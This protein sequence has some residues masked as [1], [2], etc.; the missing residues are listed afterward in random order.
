MRFIAGLSEEK[1]MVSEAAIVADVINQLQDEQLVQPLAEL[2][3]T[4]YQKFENDR[5]KRIVYGLLAGLFRDKP[6][7]AD[8]EWFVQMGE[9]YKLLISK[10]LSSAQLFDASGENVQRYVFYDDSDAKASFA[11]FIASYKNDPNWRTVAYEQYVE[12]TSVYGHKVTILANKPRDIEKSNF[13]VDEAFKVKNKVPSVIAHRGH[14][15]FFN[16]TIGYV[17]PDVVFV[18]VGACGGAKNVGQLLENSPQAQIAATR[19]VGTMRINDPLFKLINNDIRTQGSV[20]WESVWTRAEK[21]AW[22]KT[23]EWGK[24][25][26]PH[27]NVIESFL[28]SYDNL[29]RSSA[30]STV[31]DLATKGGIDLNAVDAALRINSSTQTAELAI[32]PVLFEQYRVSPGFYPEIKFMRPVKNVIEYLTAADTK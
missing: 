4:Q 1:D 8:R 13:A 17:T 30:S 28:K 20:Y 25:V 7:S 2:I 12:V 22:S 19:G 32:D 3:K 9:E 15:Y 31:G 11:H 5:Q 23:N 29:M 26:A 6:V 14:S 18:G 27:R 16:G 21:Q 24:Y 10:E